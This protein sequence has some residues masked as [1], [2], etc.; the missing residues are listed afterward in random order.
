MTFDIKMSNFLV[1]PWS[2]KRGILYTP[3]NIQLVDREQ[4]TQT[5]RIIKHKDIGFVGGKNDWNDPSCYGW[6]DPCGDFHCL[7][8]R[9]NQPG[10]EDVQCYL[11]RRGHL[12]YT[13]EAHFLHGWWVKTGKATGRT[14][15]SFFHQDKGILF[16]DTPPDKISTGYSTESGWYKRSP[17]FMK[18]KYARQWAVISSVTVE[19]VQEI[20]EADA[21]AEGVY[22][23]GKPEIYHGAKLMHTTPIAAYRDIWESINGPG[24]WDLNP[25]VWVIK[26]MKVDRP[27]GYGLD[28]E[29]WQLNGAQKRFFQNEE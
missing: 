6:E 3:E 9:G 11:G 5:R 22:P 16:L 29:G 18:E 13:K 21:I 28:P 7:P 24:S 15:W 17:L 8:E 12:L 2:K 14:G 10:R 23:R 4:K 1:G 27:L 26:F 20:S 25:W 19:R